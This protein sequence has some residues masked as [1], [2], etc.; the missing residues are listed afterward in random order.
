MGLGATI[1]DDEP[2]TNGGSEAGLAL[3]SAAPEVALKR[4]FP[5]LSA[6]KRP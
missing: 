5:G 1:Q 3:E 2:A 4:N 6:S